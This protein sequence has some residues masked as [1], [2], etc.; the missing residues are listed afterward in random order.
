MK[1]VA[2]SKVPAATPFL[3]LG[4]LSASTAFVKPIQGLLWG[5]LLLLFVGISMASSRFV[6]R[7]LPARTIEDGSPRAS[8]SR[9]VERVVLVVGMAAMGCAFLFGEKGR[10]FHH[11]ESATSVRLWE[12]GSSVAYLSKPENRSDSI[13][14]LPTQE[15]QYVLS[16]VLA[17]PKDPDR[18]TDGWNTPLMLQV[19]Q[20]DGQLKYTVASAG[21]ERTWGT[22]DDI[23]DPNQ[24]KGESSI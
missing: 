6:R 14:K 24:L 7:R 12:F 19:T 10:I 13:S 2:Y 9:M 15:G 11:P 1:I 20:R 16:S 5:G 8:R 3:H 23:T 22:Q 18:Y 4:Y 21:P 17:V